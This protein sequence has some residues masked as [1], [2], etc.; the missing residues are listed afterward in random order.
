MRTV[1][2]LAAVALLAG[3]GR[4]KEERPSTSRDGKTAARTEALKPVYEEA[5]AA[6]VLHAISDGEMAAARVAREVSQ[7]EGILA[8]ASVMLADHRAISE[9][10]DSVLAKNGESP[11]DNAASTALRA[12]GD[13]AALQLAALTEGFNNSYIEQEIRAHQQ[14]LQVMDT[15]LLPSARN[16]EIKSLF[17][18]VRPTIAAHLQRAM[19]ILAF[20]QKQAEERGEPFTTGT[21]APRVT[22]DTSVPR[23]TPVQRPPVDTTTP[24]LTT[25]SS[26]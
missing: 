13:T 20:R 19:Q 4:D 10:L 11:R 2:L 7:N 9:V 24:P 1:I 15:A 5:E 8:Y 16:A 12:Q 22:T 17:T 25:T 6:A 26:M 23:P 3:C 18:A 21:T 14:A